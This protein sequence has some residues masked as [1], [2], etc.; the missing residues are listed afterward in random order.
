M[1]V[2]MNLLGMSVAGFLGYSLEPN[3]RQ[4]LT[5]KSPSAVE[6][7]ASGNIMLQL[8]DGSQVPL[9]SLTKEQLPE[10]IV[11]S[12]SV[13]I[14]DLASG[15][16]MTID[17]GSQLLLLRIDRGYAVISPGPSMGEGRTP[18]MNTNLLKLLSLNPPSTTKIPA[19]TPGPVVPE[20]TEMVPPVA[21]NNPPV[22]TP[23]VTPLPAPTNP[24][25]ESAEPPVL[26]EPPPVPA[27]PPIPEPAPVSPTPAPGGTPAV[28]ATGEADIVKAMKDSIQS[29]QIKEFKSD[30]V[31]QWKGAAD[32][33]ADGE[34]YQTGTILYKAETFLGTKTIEAKA[35]IKAGKVQRWIWPRS[36]MEIK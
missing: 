36:G 29:G 11:I 8:A 31:L 6:V 2:L 22:E 3:M 15:L 33:S 24:G 19:K 23:P 28:A 4:Q 35:F 34:T 10:K 5:G 25:G 12:N 14:N 21:A 18:V 17:P 26:A 20:I 32:E 13:K 9:D 16:T 1:K 7:D 30:Q 27:P